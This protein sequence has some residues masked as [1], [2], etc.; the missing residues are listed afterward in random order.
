MEFGCRGVEGSTSYIHTYIYINTYLHTYI[1]THKVNLG[2]QSLKYHKTPSLK[3]Y[4]SVCKKK[5]KILKYN[6][7][8]LKIKKKKNPKYKLH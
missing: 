2:M 7:D 3:I 5:K 1:L 6:N 8:N 4:I